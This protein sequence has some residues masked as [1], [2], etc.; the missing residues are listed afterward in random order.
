MITKTIKLETTQNAALNAVA[1]HETH[2]NVSH[3]IREAIEWYLNTTP[4][5]R[6]QK[7]I[8]NSPE[9]ILSD[10]QYNVQNP[11]QIATIIFAKEKDFYLHSDVAN[12]T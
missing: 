2:G 3:A 4:Q 9:H 8:T 10:V 1:H 5:T 11:C 7:R 6:R 12:G